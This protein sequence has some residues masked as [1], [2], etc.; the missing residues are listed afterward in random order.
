M[1][2]LKDVNKKF[3]KF[4]LIDTTFGGFILSKEPKIAPAKL[5]SK[6]LS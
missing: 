2:I 1:H 5:S 3:Q 6:F 4:I